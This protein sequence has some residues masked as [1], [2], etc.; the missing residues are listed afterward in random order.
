MDWETTSTAELFRSYRAVLAELRR[1]EIVRTGNAPTGDYAETLVCVAFSGKLAPNSEKSWDVITPDKQRLQVK[2]R[3]LDD[4]SRAK[5]RQLSA[6]R[7]WAFD[8]L[9]IVLFDSQ[10][11][12]WRAVEIPV[13]SIRK[14][15]TH[16]D[17]VNGELIIARDSLLNHSVARDLTARLRKVAKGL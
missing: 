5:Q 16:S 10:Y 12:V 9:I 14:M 4:P 7:S 17:W 13:K 2:S 3:L 8:S 6:V 15:G 1:R 11:I